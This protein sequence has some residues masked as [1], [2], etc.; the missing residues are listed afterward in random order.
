MRREEAVVGG[1]MVVAHVK[2][3]QIGAQGFCCWLPVDF[4]S[5]FGKLTVAL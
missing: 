2:G 4:F 3:R 1:H 5:V